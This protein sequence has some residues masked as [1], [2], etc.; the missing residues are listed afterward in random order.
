M[1]EKLMYLWFIKVSKMEFQ[2]ATYTEQSVEQSLVEVRE[3]FESNLKE[4]YRVDHISRSTTNGLSIYVT[5]VRD[6]SDK[7]F[8]F[9][10]SDHESGLGVGVQETSLCYKVNGKNLFEMYEVYGDMTADEARLNFLQ[11]ALSKSTPGSA[12]YN[13][14]KKHIEELTR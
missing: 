4:G 14:I 2:R 10:I 12:S 11:K 3:Y 7:P 9:R 8:Q 1:F 5:V 13:S 6:G